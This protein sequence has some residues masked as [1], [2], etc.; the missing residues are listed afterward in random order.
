VGESQPYRLALTFSFQPSEA[1]RKV[2]TGNQWC[3]SPGDV[4]QF[5]RFIES[6]AGFIALQDAKPSRVEL[7]L[8]SG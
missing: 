5:R 6:S 2:G 4:P 8:G 3:R 1:L 7:R